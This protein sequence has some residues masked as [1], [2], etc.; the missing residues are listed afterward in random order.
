MEIFTRIVNDSKPYMFGK[1]L[2]KLQ[3]SISKGPD[4]AMKRVILRI[5]G[6][7]SVTVG[8]LLCN[9][10]EITLW[11]RCS[12]VNLLHIFRTLFPKNPSRW[13]LL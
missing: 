3:L 9:F 5:N 7:P 11:H 4:Y 8:R 12:S 1:A 2:N 13:L 6:M 10:I